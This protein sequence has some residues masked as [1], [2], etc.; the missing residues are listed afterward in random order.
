MFIVFIQS[1]HCCGIGRLIFAADD[2]ALLVKITGN[3]YSLVDKMGQKVRVTYVF[4][5]R[6]Q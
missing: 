3:A 5:V 6:D 1:I 2:P 4:R